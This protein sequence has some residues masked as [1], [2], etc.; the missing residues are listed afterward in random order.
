[1]DKPRPKAMDI[2]TPRRTDSMR[3]ARQSLRR[4]IIWTAI[5]LL[6]IV[7]SLLGVQS[8]QH[9]NDQVIMKDRYQVVYL[10]TGQVYFGQLQNTSGDYLTLK[11]V[12]TLE[13]KSSTADPVDSTN[14]SNI[15]QVSRQVYGPEDSMAIRADQV[16]FWQNLR[17]DSKVAQ[18][19]KSANQ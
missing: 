12:Y 10:L 16:Q 4:Q 13:A 8:Y 18:A 2:T 15:L 3:Y 11:N 7:G 17:S 6:V 9:R 19:I 5:A 1:M 14:T